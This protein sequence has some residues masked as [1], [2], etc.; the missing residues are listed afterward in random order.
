MCMKSSDCEL[1]ERVNAIDKRVTNLE[2]NVA[3]M[4]RESRDGFAQ[5]SASV[6]ALGHDFGERMNTLDKKI[7][8]EKSKWGDTLR[9]IVQWTVGTVLA[10]AGAAAGVNIV[11]KFFP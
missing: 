2:G 9:K 8:D 5:L 7:V 11:G 1:N 4:R 6:N 3:E 10:L